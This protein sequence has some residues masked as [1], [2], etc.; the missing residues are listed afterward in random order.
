MITKE[1]A[2]DKIEALENGTIQVRQVSRIIEDGTEL[3]RSFNRWVLAPGVDI[4]NQDPRVQAIC[5]AV[6]TPEVIAAFQAK[7]EAA[8]QQSEA[9]RQAA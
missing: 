2:I 9:Q 6:W 7:Q 4:S 1:V 8:R 3:S 5:N